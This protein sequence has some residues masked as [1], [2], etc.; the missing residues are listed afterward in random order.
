[1]TDQIYDQLEEAQQR[2]LDALQSIED[3][4]GLQ[5][6]RTA[7]LG[8]SSLVMQVFSGLGK[9]DK[10]IR[11]QVG[12]RANQTKQALEAALEER[13]EMMRQAALQRSLQSEALDVT[14]PGRPFSR[15][16]LHI[17]TQ[18]LREIYRVFGDMG[19]QVYRSRE[20][21]TDDYNFGLLNMPPSSPSA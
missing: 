17:T 2:G 15:G 6:W 1:M 8:R 4:A 3:E 21:E 7:H 12:Q 11:P 10:E 19:F 18:V 5:A 9:L 13:S 20:I 16:R 14:L